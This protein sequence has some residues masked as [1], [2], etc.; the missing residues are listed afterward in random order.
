[1]YETA[2][3]EERNQSYQ[4]GYGMQSP[5][6]ERH[7]YPTAHAV[8]SNPS[9]RVLTPPGTNPLDILGHVASMHREYSLRTPSNESQCCSPGGQAASKP[10]AI[11]GMLHLVPGNMLTSLAAIPSSHEPSSASPEELAFKR[12]MSSRCSEKPS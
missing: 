3:V 6:T 12:N 10:L 8:N 7:A 5:A 2:Y 11:P 9:P 4:Y 1:V